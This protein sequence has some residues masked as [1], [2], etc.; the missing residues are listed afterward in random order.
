MGKPKVGDK[1]RVLPRKYGDLD[2]SPFYAD[3]MQF[4]AGE[5]RTVN[6]ITGSGW[7]ILDG[8]DYSWSSDWLVSS[9]VRTLTRK[10][11]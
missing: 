3:E 8:L 11:V 1:V 5:V 2:K 7:Y 6:S 4:Y 10:V 9:K